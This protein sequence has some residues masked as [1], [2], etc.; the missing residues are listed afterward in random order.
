MTDL[1]DDV[2][3]LARREGYGREPRPGETLTYITTPRSIT[4]A[5][6]RIDPSNPE[7]L[8]HIPKRPEQW[9]NEAWLYYD[10]VPEIKFA[11]RFNGNALSR[12]QLRV[13]ADVSPD[14][15][16]VEVEEA[17]GEEGITASLAAAALDETIRM[18]DADVMSGHMHEFGV[19]LTIPGDSY[20]V[21]TPETPTEPE[22]WQVYSESAISRTK[23][24]L[25]LR[26]KPGA[27]PELL[28]PGTIA[29]RIWRRHS[30][31]PG[32]TDS[33]VRSILSEIEELLIYSRQFR[34]VGKS[35]NAAGLL[36]LHQDLDTP[37]PATGPNGQAT[38]LT[39]LEAGL[40][41]SLVTPTYDDASASSVVPHIVRGKGRPDDMIKL[42]ALDRKIDDQAIARV[43]FL[44]QRCAHGLDMPVEVLTGIA[45]MNHWNAWAMEDQ[46]YRMHI[47]P[48]A[49]V[50][51]FGLA[52]A[53]L[54]PA[55]LARG[56][57]QEAVARV[58]YEIDPSSLVVRPNRAQDA[59][60]AFDRLGIS[61]DRLRKDL[62]YG[63]DDAPSP[64]EVALRAAM[65][66]GD[67]R[68]RGNTGAEA[69][70]LPAGGNTATGGGQ[71]TMQPREIAQAYGLIPR[72]HIAIT[73]SSTPARKPVDIGSRLA[74]IEARLRQRLVSSASQQLNGVLRQAGNR[75]KNRAQGTPE[76]RAMTKGIAPEAICPTLGPLRVAALANGDGQ[77]LDA[78][79]FDETAWDF[80]R[81]TRSAQDKAVALLRQYAPDDASAQAAIET[82]QRNQDANRDTA[83]AA[84]VA[85]L[86]AWGTS[87]LF[88]PD[89]KP[90]LGEWNDRL[91]VP[92]SIVRE[93]LSLAGGSRGAGRDPGGVPGTDDLGSAGGLFAGPDMQAALGDIGVSVDEW[94]WFCG[95][96]DRPFEPHHD[97]EGVTFQGFDD[98]LL[99]NDLSWPEYEFFWPGDHEGCECWAVAVTSQAETTEG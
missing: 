46:A 62:G 97:L 6:R 43:T 15:A 1:A 98:P 16:P 12:L 76:L 95:D 28:P 9:Q 67:F 44:I 41:Q 58:G 38:N 13:V 51:A 82:F 56:F 64:E 30:R 70:G 14:G 92:T 45:D 33:N 79:Q 66:L 81:W 2:A 36:Y 80:D 55:L 50:P 96:P 90:D 11:G 26:Q 69:N 65:G 5:A 54:R 72:E 39:T 74:A 31:W 87:R 22:T 86:L 75:M 89:G 27:R 59:K 85:A 7:D 78:E 47:Q 61:W 17:V 71:A 8:V 18:G 49:S 88:T 57:P 60:D 40:T 77:L 84:L 83:K 34:A 21:V 94:E 48:L 37:A 68:A 29:H 73:A 42:F 91:S 3:A 23:Q 4:A 24:G 19:D 10:A 35:R 25:T 93:A 63:D 20:M 52:K 53:H 99:T 32:L